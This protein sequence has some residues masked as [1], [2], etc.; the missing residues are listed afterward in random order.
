[1]RHGLGAYP[2]SHELMR[3][4]V[5]L[6]FLLASI[7]ADQNESIP[8]RSPA[9]SLGHGRPGKPYDIGMTHEMKGWLFLMASLFL[10]MVICGLAMI[11]LLTRP[12]RWVER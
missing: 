4:H 8:E 1:M 3:P 10:L 9:V 7:S 11:G 5:R 6:V 2:V 12:A